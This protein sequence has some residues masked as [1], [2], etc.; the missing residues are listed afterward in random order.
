MEKTPIEES[1]I[2]TNGRFVHYGRHMEQHNQIHQLIAKWPSRAEL[3]SDL[4]T[5]TGEIVPVD[6]IH[7]W[8]QTGSIPS[9]YQLHVLRAADARQFDM[10]P[11][12]MLQLHAVPT[13]KDGA[14]A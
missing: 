3:A 12:E 2:L 1:S 6:R 4:T 7:K 13:Q 8:A 11:L 14:A 5:I 9:S 10:T